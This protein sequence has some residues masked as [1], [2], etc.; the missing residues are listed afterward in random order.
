MDTI[1]IG[2]ALIVL[3][4]AP[5]VWW[6]ASALRKRNRRR[7]EAA[8]LA[9]PPPDPLASLTESLTTNLTGGLEEV[10][11]SLDKVQGLMNNLQEQGGETKEKLEN[12]ANANTSLTEATNQLQ[13]LLDNRSDR[14][15]WGER[16]AEDLLRAAGLAENYGYRKQALIANGKQPDFTLILPDRKVLH[17]EVKFPLDNYRRYAEAE[18]EPE[19]ERYLK[20]FI[21]N[22]KK[23]INETAKR[24]YA[25]AE[26]SVGFGLLLIPM[27][28]VWSVIVQHNE[29]ELLKEAET[30]KIA[31]CSP[32][33]LFPILMMIRNLTDTF[34]MVA[35]G[36]EIIKAVSEFEQEWT[37]YIGAVE[38]VETNLNAFAKSIRVL[39]STRT[40]V[41]QRK[42]NAVSALRADPPPPPQ[43]TRRLADRRRPP[44]ET[45]ASVD[46]A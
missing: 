35:H 45:S 12:V 39:T 33:T 11:G 10:R 28:S 17:M 38:K 2:I 16:M 44:A 13:T 4:A 21:G 15:A 34:Q 5:A 42:V 8:A 30:K 43:A 9:P 32:A 29:G 20:T 46:V 40:N 22:A 25:E 36:Q 19:A 3:L 41:L 18:S 14:G 27:E 37:T 31:L 26:D 7:E 6:A 23:A 1:L 24:G